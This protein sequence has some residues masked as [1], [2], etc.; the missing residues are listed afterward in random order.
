MSPQK[1]DVV[2]VLRGVP[3]IPVLI[4]DDVAAA[5]PTARALVAGGL[6]VLE[7]TL[8]TPVA[9]DCVRRIIAEVPD[10]TVGVGT[11]L[12]PEQL[13]QSEE[14]GVAFAV[15]PG[16][17]ARLLDAADDSAV[18]LLPGIATVSEAMTLAERGY[19]MLKFF[20]AE[21][22]GGVNA[23]RS[24]ASPLPGLRFCPTGGITLAKAPDYLRLP[25]VVCVGGSWLAP[26]D[27]VKKGDW[28][29]IQALA[30]EASG[31]KG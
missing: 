31:L 28:A 22:I 19:D 16:A 2:A 24:F 20:P 14:D 21:A 3:V 8:R 18:P 12:T 25:N 23:L 5:V 30:A 6:P 11:V 29:A 7:I 15:S 4:F 9:R 13:R 17:T 27:A 1:K 26:S 10:A